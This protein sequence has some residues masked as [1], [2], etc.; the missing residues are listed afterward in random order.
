MLFR[1]APRVGVEAPRLGALKAPE[2]LKLVRRDPMRIGKDTTLELGEN[3]YLFGPGTEMM[4]SEN[5]GK[6][7]PVVLGLGGKLIGRSGYTLDT[8]IGLGRMLDLDTTQWG[9]PLAQLSSQ[10][11]R[12][13]TERV[14]L[15]AHVTAQTGEHISRGE[16][17]FRLNYRLDDRQQWLIQHRRYRSE[18][19][20]LLDSAV[21]EFSYSL[22]L[23]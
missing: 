13:L 21:T 12:T 3:S 2:K 14:D 7:E 9:R 15:Q 16:W 5:A 18:D 23:R 6:P 8:S 10:L 17:S 11:T 19:T 4:E 22:K 20:D 1:P